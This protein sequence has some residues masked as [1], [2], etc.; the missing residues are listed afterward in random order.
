[1]TN[2]ARVR[3][4]F[5]LVLL[6][7]LFLSGCGD[8]KQ[9]QQGLSAVDRV[10]SEVASILGKKADEIDISKPLVAQGADEL[11]I[12]EIVMAVEEAFK[13]E[14]PDSVIG[15]K[16]GEVSKTLTVEKLAEVV[17]KQKKIK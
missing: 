13:V 4:G 3:T 6:L 11:D 8:S 12:V 17:S 7:C 9:K 2:D 14:I 16:I 1:M 5:S 10:R 15:E